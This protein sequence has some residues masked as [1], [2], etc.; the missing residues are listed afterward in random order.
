[1]PMI[2]FGQIPPADVQKRILEIARLAVE[3]NETKQRGF[4]VDFDEAA[5]TWKTPSEL[6]E[7]NFRRFRE[8]ARDFLDETFRQIADLNR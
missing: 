3:A 1:M 6:G 5:S 2:I 4:Y 7:S 8:F